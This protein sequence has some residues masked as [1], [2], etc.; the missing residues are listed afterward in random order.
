MLVM[1]RSRGGVFTQA[2]ARTH[3]HEFDTRRHAL[4]GRMGA[5]GL[6]RCVGAV[7]YGEPIPARA[8]TA[9]VTKTRS[10]ERE[11]KLRY[12]NCGPQQKT[13]RI[14]RRRDLPG[15]IRGRDA[16]EQMPILIQNIRSIIERELRKASQTHQQTEQ[17]DN[18]S[19]HL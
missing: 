3:L 8:V 7:R 1:F 6:G 16:R 17:V 5:Y 15:S 13:R 18:T 12:I 9:N 4:E 14:A 19:A 2:A 10:T 11:R